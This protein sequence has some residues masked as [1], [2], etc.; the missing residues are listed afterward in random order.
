MRTHLLLILFV[1]ITTLPENSNAREWIIDPE[2]SSVSFE[3]MVQG[4]PLLGEFTDFDVRV[5][6]DPDKLEASSII[7]EVDLSSVTMRNVQAVQMLKSPQW[8]N[9][10]GYAKATFQS[11]FIERD[12]GAYHAIG[13]LN[14]K[15]V[16]HR[17]RLP[18][19]IL[20]EDQKA[21]ATSEFALN[22]LEFSIG[23]GNWQSGQTVS[24][25]VIVRLKITAKTA[26]KLRK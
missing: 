7:A 3:A 14:I 15:S 8:F 10:S 26:Q 22:R 12:D 5:H 19:S 21:I 2:S 23:E 13:T 20:I 6:F 25:D 24:H 4:A 18:F 9:I 1:T 17:I 16:S 11:Q